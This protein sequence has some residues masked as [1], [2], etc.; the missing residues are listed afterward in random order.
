M[1]PLNVIACLVA[2]GF[3]YEHEHNY[4]ETFA[5][6]AHMTTV[7]ILLVVASIRKCPNAFLFMSDPRPR[8]SVPKGMV[9]R[10]RRSL[11]GLK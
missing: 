1:V 4:D 9:C 10:L 2:H 6:V 3:Q 5:H 11:Y 8:Y 7:C